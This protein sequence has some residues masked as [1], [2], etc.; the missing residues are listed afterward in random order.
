MQNFGKI[1][2]AY[3]ELLVDSIGKNKADSKKKLFKKYVK[4]I[5][6]N[7]ILKLQF[8]VYNNIENR[9]DSD[10]NSAAHFIQENVSL[11]SKYPAND[12]I[13][14]NEKL[15]S[16]DKGLELNESYDLAK[17]HAS[18]NNLITTKK[19]PT[20]IDSLTND[21]KQVVEHINSNKPRE[22]NENIDLP[23]GLLSNMMVDKFN[24]RYETLDES[25][26]NIIK[27]LNSSDSVDKKSVYLET[28]KE[29]VGLVNDRLKNT[30]DADTKDKLLMVKDKLLND[31]DNPV[32]KEYISEISK[33]VSLK[34]TLVN[35]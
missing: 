14:A 20:N 10:F 5:K 18:I 9:I 8:L 1:K 19:T 6:E 32:D 3:N 24:E 29:C 34:K 2:N 7:E 31:K 35:D 26:K 21:L 33:L 30:N 25:D 16:L 4:T 23:I 22:I 17:V 27:V 15:L 13:K 11:L 28:I 12:I